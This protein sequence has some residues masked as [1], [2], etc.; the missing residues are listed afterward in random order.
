MGRI[1]LVALA[2]VAACAQPTAPGAEPFTSTA[3][4]QPFIRGVITAVDPQ[5]GF[6]V[7]ARP[8]GAYEVDVAI[9][10]ADEATKIQRA[11]A[12][13]AKWESLMAGQTV[14]VWIRGPVMESLPVQVIA[15]RIVVE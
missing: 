1:L 11:G 3:S 2:L 14:S 6:R 10:R 5:R 12:G 4:T 7:E 8:A 13:D 15:E 9:V